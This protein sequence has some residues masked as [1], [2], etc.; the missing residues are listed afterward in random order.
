MRNSNANLLCA[1]GLT[2]SLTLPAGRVHCQEAL[3]YSLAGEAAAEAN[4][5]QVENQ[6]YTFKTGD[7]KVLVSPSVGFDW[8]DNVYL[9]KDNPQ[10]DF[11]LLPALTIGASYPITQKNLLQLDVTIGYDD[12]LKH[13]D[14]SQ[15]LITSGSALSFDFYT[16]D[17]AFNVHDRFSYMQDSATQAAVANTGTVRHLPK[18]RWDLWNLGSAGRDSELGL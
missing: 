5:L 13:H 16:G 14:L 12:Y 10:D 18:H 7:L 8:N 4:R 2:A 15:L 17:F 3:H 11:I 6:A 9:T 1:A